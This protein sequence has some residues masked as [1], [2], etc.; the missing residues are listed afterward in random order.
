VLVVAV[1]DVTQMFQATQ[2]V[3]LLALAENLL[4]ADE[5]L[6]KTKLKQEAQTLTPGLVAVELI[7]P[8]IYHLA[9]EDQELL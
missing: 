9:L 4:E 2:L 8:L 7:T 1:A 3:I 6:V 5:A